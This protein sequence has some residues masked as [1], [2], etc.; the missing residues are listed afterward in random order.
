MFPRIRK[1]GRRSRYTQRQRPRTLTY[2][3]LEQKLVMYNLSGATWDNSDISY[4]FVPDGTD[5]TTARGS[6]PSVLYESLDLRTTT[7]D[8]Q[9]MI[10]QSLQ[11]WA[12]VSQ[13]NFHQVGDDGVPSGTVSTSQGDIRIAAVNAGSASGWAY[14][15]AAGIGGD[16][17]LR[18]TAPK[19]S[20]LY[21]T[22]NRFRV[23][24][25]HEAGHALGL[26][27]TDIP[28][29]IMG[30]SGGL[31]GLTADDIAG[32][33][34]IYGI[35]Q[36]DSFDKASRND[37]VSTASSIAFDGSSL[38]FRADLT[39]HADVDHYRVSIPE[40]AQS[41]TV[42][43]DARE[44][45]LLAPKVA[46]YDS[47]GQL[48]ATA[49]GEYG[50]VATVNVSGLIAGQNYTI[51]ADGATT[52]EFG[53]GAYR[54][55]AQL[56][57]NIIT[58]PTT[59]PP[60]T[61]PVNVVPP[62]PDHG[63]NT[64][65]TPPV[66]PEPPVTPVV[67][68]PPTPTTP[69]QPTA[70]PMTPT[71]NS[72]GGRSTLSVA[73][74]RRLLAAGTTSTTTPVTPPIVTT[75]PVTPIVDV[76]PE[77]TRPS[78]TPEPETPAPPVTTPVV[79][80]VPVTPPVVETPSETPTVTPPVVVTPPPTT[81]VAPLSPTTT[82]VVRST[83][84]IAS[85]RRL[86]AGRTTTA[87]A[88]A[89]A[90]L[91]ANFEMV[92]NST[93]QLSTTEASTPSGLSSNNPIPAQS[94]PMI[95]LLSLHTHDHDHDYV[96]EIESHDSQ[97]SEIIS[98]LQSAEPK[99]LASSATTEQPAVALYGPMNIRSLRRVS[100]AAPTETKS[101]ALPLNQSTASAEPL[102]IHSNTE[103]TAEL[104]V[105]TPCI[106]RPISQLKHI[107]SARVN[108]ASDSA[109]RAEI[110]TALNPA[111]IDELFARAA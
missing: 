47:H 60:T 87:Q 53:M 10:A 103:S 37:S 84:T 91:P 19:F 101:T 70:P 105:E 23:L 28:N 25:M 2:E 94:T 44:L 98:E 14:F 33:Q 110:A 109:P 69:V 88:P 95:G 45:S 65:H 104:K 20:E 99:L 58:P 75:P 48:V 107:V 40:G 57:G 11:R 17:T 16:I 36:D 62:D 73:S 76:T 34:A 6:G 29:T 106:A 26:D 93:A 85:L 59:L 83:L 22:D 63:E 38:G 96:P 100:E 55:A 78:V 30:I 7:N 111:H 97:D 54:L 79:P 43:V 41:M 50:T 56:T 4:S 102:R 66:T 82:P 80:T 61:P 21:W 31:V 8:W 64:N 24:V 3:R 89:P 52:D 90:N 42:S 35:R 39:S 51:V 49:S 108:S 15:P 9:Y 67:T 81:P 12:N 72:P 46:V 74:L 27:H 92:S 86:L 77:P 5:W 1:L 71:T 32:I 68:L 18:A 13:L